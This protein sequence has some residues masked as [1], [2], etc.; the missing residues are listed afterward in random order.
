MISPDKPL[1]CINKKQAYQIQKLSNQTLDFQNP[2][3]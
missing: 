1:I 3:L 2:E